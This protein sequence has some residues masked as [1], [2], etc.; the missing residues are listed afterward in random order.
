[1]RVCSTSLRTTIEEVL[2]SLPELNP[3]RAYSEDSETTRFRLLCQQSVDT[4]DHR[5]TGVT[6]G[7]H[8]Q[9]VK[10][11]D[12]EVNYLSSVLQP[13]LDGQPADPAFLYGPSGAGKTCIAQ[14]TIECLRENVV[15]LNHQYVNCWEDYSRFKTL[16]TLLDG[17]G[18]TLDI[19]RQ[20]TPKDVLLDRL[21]NYEGPPYIVILDEVDQLEDKSLLYDL[22]RILSITM[23][24]IANNEEGLFASIDDRL[25]SRLTDCTRIHFRQYRNNEIVAILKD[26]VRWGLQGDIVNEGRLNT[27]ANN[28]AGD[29]RVAIGILRKAARASKKNNL[30]EIP[31]QVIRNVVPEAK[32]EIKQKTVS[33]L[34]PHQ[35]TLYEIITEYGEIGPQDLHEEYRCRVTD[36]K[37]QRMV[38]NYLSKLEHYN[39]IRSEGN[40]KARIYRAVA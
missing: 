32:T 1:M 39:L 22:Y 6:T 36:P 19:H 33:R 38:R 9:E 30:N 23:I 28:A 20:S 2:F 21:R 35:Q 14:F 15:E 31:E 5:C 40:T 12:G 24:L 13:I 7:V 26:R 25:N 18:Q 27:V 8:P 10:H 37:T 3:E 34:T 4:H 17:I 29:A 11:R 16:Y